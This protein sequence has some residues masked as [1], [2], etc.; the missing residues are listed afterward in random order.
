[1][2]PAMDEKDFFRNATTRI[3]GSLEI[4]KALWNAFLYIRNFIPASQMALHLYDRN[5]GVVETVARAT[6]EGYQ[7]LSLKLPLSKTGRDQAEKQR[8]MRI[9]RIDTVKND[10][11]AATVSKPFAD[12]NLAGLVMDLVI[13]KKFLGTVTLHSEPG[14]KFS[15][16]HEHLLRVLNEPF[17]IAL[18]NNIRYRKLQ[19][20]RDLLID[21]NRYL[22]H[23]LQRVSG[24]EVIGAEFG[25]RP[26]M[27]LVRQVAPRDTP[28]ML[29]GET[30]VGKELIASAIHNFSPRQEGPFIKVNCGSIPESLMDSELFGHEKGA[31]TGANARK[32]G[33]FERANTGTIFLD[34]IGELSSDAQVRL[35][36]VIQEK[37]IERVGGT[38]TINLDIRVIAATHR[39]LEKM[40]AE[41]RFRED[42]YFRL[43]VFPIVIPPLRSRMSDLPSLV[44]HFIQKK[45]LD[46][47]LG[48][49]PLLAPGAL[50]SLM[51]YPWPGN[52][53][54]LENAVERALI[55]SGDNTI[56]FNDIDMSACR[57]PNPPEIHP[58]DLNFTGLD[59]AMARHIQ[60][61]LCNSC[62]KI[63]GKNG[64]AELLQINPKTL[65]NRMRKLGVPFG[66]KAKMIYS[67][68]IP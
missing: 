12:L 50:E 59:T 17:A 5:T 56:T 35:L 66:K 67:G 63:E 23:E 28:V 65:R 27:E 14:K 34:E 21:N 51:S 10:T 3:C 25:L 9:R 44:Q 37:E 19:K 53:R 52:V 42:L 39:N 31:F 64:A 13:E 45:S 40:L 18:T 46:L 4:E 29:L 48:K 55:L 36:R 33:R 58:R 6:P 2:S 24:E 41:G 16:D 60:N 49:I 22:Q 61:A 26:V 1:M 62:G 38:E 11:I 15:T 8:S 7:A 43:K 20:Y 68:P 32:R 57:A 30:G 47:K 54:E